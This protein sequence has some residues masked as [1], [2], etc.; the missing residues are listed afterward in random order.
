MLRLKGD[1]KW[2]H[3][4]FFFLCVSFFNRYIMPL[5]NAA[6]N[7]YTVLAWW[8]KDCQCSMRHGLQLAGIILLW[9][10]GLNIDWDCLWSHYIVSSRNRWEFPPYL[11]R[12]WQQMP[13]V[14][15]V[16]WGRERVSCCKCVSGWSV[17]ALDFGMVVQT[18]HRELNLLYWLVY[19]P[20]CKDWEVIEHANVVLCFQK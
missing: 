7:C 11:R 4:W 12:H 13:A 14:R 5:V 15:A 8:Q 20:I 6:I 3:S 1:G 19:S 16:K 17:A 9:L 10:V 18:T 2:L